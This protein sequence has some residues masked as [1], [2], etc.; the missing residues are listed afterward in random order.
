MTPDEPLTA[1]DQLPRDPEILIYLTHL[2]GPQTG[3]RYR[4]DDAD[5]IR[6]GRGVD[7]QVMLSDPLSSRVHAYVRRIDGAWQ[8]IDNNSRNGTLLDGTKIETAPLKSGS[9]IRIG[10]VELQ[11]EII[12]EESSE[13]QGDDLQTLVRQFPLAA[14]GPSETVQ[15]ALA[16]LRDAVQAQQLLILYQLSIKLLGCDQPDDVIHIALDLLRDQ[17]RA[18]SA[19]FLWID[20]TGHL[21]PKLQLPEGSPEQLKLSETLSALVSQQGNAVWINRQQAQRT[22]QSLAHFADAICIPLVSMKHVVGAMLA[23]MERGK[24]QQQDFDFG[25][26]LANIV[27]VALVRARQ[28]VTLTQ[29]HQRLSLKH[30]ELDEI[31]GHS[32]PIVELK[33]RMSRVARASGCV[34]IRGESG[35]GKELV[36]RGVHR[37]GPRADRPLLTVNCAAIPSEL[38]ESQLFGHKA[39]A[40]TG[41]DRDHQGFFQQA[42]SGT[43]FLDE[44]GELSL[45]GQA[46]LL[47]ILEGHP[48]QPVG[49]KKAVTV[50]VRVI[51]ATN[52]DLLA[53]VRERRF[54]EDLYYRLSVFELKIP[55]LRERGTDLALLLDYFL[56][57]FK[58]LHGRSTLQL[59]AAARAKLLAYHWP[60]NVRQMRNVIDSTIVMT[61]G[62]LI[63]SADLG[64][65][66]SGPGVELDTLRIDHW[67]RK[68]IIEA[69]KRA[70][71]NVPES[72]KLLGLSRATL[73][74]K[75][76]EYQIERTRLPAEL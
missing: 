67:E 74:R 42:D 43:L 3:A 41:A 59:S 47:R 50:D 24:F 46:K 31:V 17:T 70:G 14:T 35:V 62:P 33:E 27:A 76:D 49:S 21:K 63:E 37:L 52:R 15:M 26:S 38:M 13:P 53:E 12:A 4:L 57:Y 61:A 9:V 25:I 19:A 45:E 36:A 20:D 60:G 6:L 32:P 8:V 5:E 22:G 23:Y 30:A 69:L 29:E 7:C 56:H 66:D 48:F 65:H 28:H 58:R 54:R 16:G 1:I 34:L 72:A 40:F 73:Y 64:L 10:A 18:S 39:G 2:N 75:L 51:A 55:A 11:F 44:V 71:G 68:L